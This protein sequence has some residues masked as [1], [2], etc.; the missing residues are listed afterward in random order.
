MLLMDNCGIQRGQQ[1]CGASVENNLVRDCHL[2]KQATN[3]SILSNNSALCCLVN[4]VCKHSLSV[5]PHVCWIIGV[6]VACLLQKQEAIDDKRGYYSIGY[7]TTVQQ[8]PHQPS[9]KCTKPN[10]SKQ[11]W[12]TDLAATRLLLILLPIHLTIKSIKTLHLFPSATSL[13][14]T[15]DNQFGQ[16]LQTLLHYFGCLTIS[17]ISMEHESISECD[18]GTDESNQHYPSP[19]HYHQQQQQQQ[20]HQ[21]YSKNPAMENRRHSRTSFSKKSKPSG[22]LVAFFALLVSTLVFQQTIAQDITDD[23]IQ[24]EDQIKVNDV[25]TILLKMIRLESING[26]R[27]YN[28]HF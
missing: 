24:S 8:R 5:T 27:L 4:I 14:K 16:P 7:I 11:H 3:K 12:L 13:N 26:C 18:T 6:V 20:Q 23:G 1:F 28:T 19:H 2:I 25:F 17:N 22:N 21:Q 9:S 15:L 10:F